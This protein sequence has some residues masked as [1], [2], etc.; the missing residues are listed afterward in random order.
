MGTP[1]MNK[2]L[3]INRCSRHDCYSIAIEDKTG[4][5]RVT[6]SKCCGSWSTFKEFRMSPSN[7][8]ELGALAFVAGG[9]T[10]FQTQVQG[11]MGQCFKPEVCEDMTERGDR[12]LEET[13][14]ML[15]ANG[16]DRARIP[17][18]VDYVY[19]RPPG[20]PRQEVGGVMVT[21]AAYCN[22]ARIDMEKA[23]NEELARIQQPDVMAKIQAK[24]A[25]KA[26]LPF[27]TPLPSSEAANRSKTSPNW[28][29]KALLGLRSKVEQGLKNPPGPYTQVEILSMMDRIEEDTQ[30]SH[31]KC[32]GL[33][34]WVECLLAIRGAMSPAEIRTYN[35][36]HADEELGEET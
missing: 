4:G 34:G 36:A 23:G 17:V 22:A 19:G 31:T 10:T 15:Q 2:K 13:I 11:W 29:R 9:R 12:V 24:Q 33:L 18:I 27:D 20:E 5:T 30:V 6:S 25:S 35:N 8:L 28:G 7:W 21:L 3:V 32:T 1:D 16:Y 26:A 14:E